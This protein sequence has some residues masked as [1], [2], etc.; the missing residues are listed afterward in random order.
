MVASNIISRRWVSGTALSLALLCA[1]ACSRSAAGPAFARSQVPAGKGVVHIY[2][3]SAVS[4]GARSIYLSVP[5]EADN[6]L[7]LD[8]DGFFTYV[9]DPGAV[10]VGAS[11]SGETKKLSLSVAPGEEKYVRVEWGTFGSA[12][13]KEVSAAE[14]A[15]EI[16]VTRGIFACQK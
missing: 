6:C 2:R 13:M 8:G 14:G 4:G 9:T 10:N 16:G 11:G 15:R 7:A 12:E 5:F 1:S 3:P